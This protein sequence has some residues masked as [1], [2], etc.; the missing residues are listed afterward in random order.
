M[1]LFEANAKS[2]RSGE[3]SLK[4][5]SDHLD[6]QTA[7]DQQDE[8]TSDSSAPAA[9]S[10]NSRV[11]SS[12]EPVNCAGEEVKNNDEKKTDSKPPEELID[13]TVVFEKNKYDISM[14]ATETVAS[15]KQLLGKNF[16]SFACVLKPVS[17]SCPRKTSRS[18]GHN[19]EIAIQRPGQTGDEFN[20]MGTEIGFQSH[21]NGNS[22]GRSDERTACSCR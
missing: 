22:T 9:P 19:S 2:C 16:R 15:L 17:D 13:F 4:R 20:G 21:F 3:A 14:S 5:N 10:L 12:S 6:A 8:S 1:T 18:T 11:C 7:S